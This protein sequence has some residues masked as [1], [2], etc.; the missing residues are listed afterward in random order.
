MKNNHLQHAG[1]PSFL[2][3]TLTLAIPVAL[4][5][6]LTSCA[7]LIDTAMVVGLG[8]AATSA[9]GIAARFSF[10]LNVI[11][12][13]FASGCRCT[14]LTVL[15]GAGSKERSSVRGTRAYLLDDLWRDLYAFA[16][17]IPER[18]DANLHR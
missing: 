8:N 14:D 11:C 17:S 7:T 2:R 10:L 15:G 5:N 18:I 1:E 13:G 9:M 3:M 6:L 12:F 4:Q 16:C